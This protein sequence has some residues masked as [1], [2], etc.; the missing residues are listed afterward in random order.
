MPTDEQTLYMWNILPFGFFC[1]ILVCVNYYSIKQIVRYSIARQL[2][3]LRIKNEWCEKD[4]SKKKTYFQGRILIELAHDGNS[5]EPYKFF[6][7][8]SKFCVWLGVSQTSLTSHLFWSFNLSKKRWNLEGG[9]VTSK[10]EWIIDNSKTFY[11]V[12]QKR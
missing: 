2:V 9:K 11:L 5:T 8:E 12:V 1:P 3:F 10:K 6:C 4:C 7:I